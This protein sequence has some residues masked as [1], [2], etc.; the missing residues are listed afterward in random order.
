MCLDLSCVRGAGLWLQDADRLASPN[1]GALIPG[2]SAPGVCR[3]AAVCGQG[4]RSRRPVVL[5]GAR[6][7]W[8]E[9]GRFAE[10]TFERTYLLADFELSPLGVAFPSKEPLS[11]LCVEE[12]KT[13]RMPLGRR[14]K[15]FLLINK[16][17]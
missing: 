9:V 5:M 2:T 3:G 8:L 10:G 15:S 1:L 4:G 17:V 7:S 16:Y 13:M 12:R 14:K 6:A 11:V